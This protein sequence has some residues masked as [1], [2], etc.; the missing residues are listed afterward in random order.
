MIEQTISSEAA[1]RFYDWL[2]ARHDWAERYEGRAKARARALL[3]LAP[4]QRAL[5]VGVG[6]GHEQSRLRAGVA[7]GGVA[8]GLDLSPVML[9]TTRARTGAPL[10]EAD[11]RQLPFA[12][13]SFDRLL[14]TYVL[15]LIPSRDLPGL[16]AEFRRVLMP[17]GRMALVSLTEGI[18]PPSRALIALW[19]L[20]YAVSPL[21]C[22]GC[23]P[24][25]LSDLVERAG[26]SLVSRAV[27]VQ[28]GLPSEVLVAVRPAE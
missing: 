8:V 9:A 5:N 27:V 6:T 20:L 22:G 24:L 21:A 15:D 2:G 10:C 14:S 28:L 3:D 4:G 13:A 17:G 11:A 1:R 19:K 16:L 18:D 26:F 23:R 7:P 12:A 25:Q